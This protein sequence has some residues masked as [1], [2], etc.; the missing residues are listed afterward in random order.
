[1]KT[2]YSILAFCAAV[3]MLSDPQLALAAEEAKPRPVDGIMD[4]SFLIEEAYNQ[5]AGIVQHI[6]TAGYYE[7]RLH[8]PDEKIWATSFTQEWPVF[9]QKHQFSYTIPYLFV[10]DGEISTDGMGDVLL[11]YRYQACF[12][13]KTLRAFA[14]R[15]SLVLPTGSMRAGF[16]D[17]TFGAQLNLPFSAAWGDHWFTHVNAGGTFLPHAATLGD[18]DA[19]HYSLGASAIYAAT[20]E[21][22]FLVEWIGN[23][24]HV[25]TED[26]GRRHEFSTLVSP[27][28]RKAFNFASGLQIVLGAAVPVGLNRASPDIGCFL[29]LSIE[30]GFLKKP[31]SH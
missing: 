5:E 11:N 17:D 25:E 19:W 10:D 6:F 3:S 1:M 15:A 4:N 23:W 2:T 29:Y 7:Q 20:P 31:A 28:V 21:L 27:G 26:G 24:N 12:D 18:R 16:T 8:D 14:P 13:E 9:S 30:H 22:H